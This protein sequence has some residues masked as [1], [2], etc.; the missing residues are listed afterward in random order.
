MSKKDKDTVFVRS[1]LDL[2]DFNDDERN[3]EPSLTDPSQDEPI[4]AL[5]ARMMRGE[6]VGHGGVQ[7]DTSGDETPA[8]VFSRQSIVTRDGFDLAD[9]ASIANRAKRAIESL[10]PVPAVPPVASKEPPKEEP[11][12]ALPDAK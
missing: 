10:K 5:V 11:P 12:K 2:G 9:A 4:E 6:L 1:V 8:E 7:F 3:T